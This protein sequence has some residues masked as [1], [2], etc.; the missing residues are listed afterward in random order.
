MTAKKLVWMTSSGFFFWV[1]YLFSRE[2]YMKLYSRPAEF[3]VVDEQ[4]TTP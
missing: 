2:M 3:W 4:L 1:S